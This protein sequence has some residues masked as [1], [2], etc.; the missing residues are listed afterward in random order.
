[1]AD[2]FT[3]IL[4]AEK[5]ENKHIL[6]LLL[7]IA[8]FNFLGCAQSI[9]NINPSDNS[10]G[11]VL[12][13][14]AK[15]TEIM[16]DYNKSDGLSEGTRLDV[17]RMNVEGMDEPVKLGEVIVQ[18]VGDKMS[19]AKLAVITSSLKME[20]GDRVFTHPITVVTDESWISR[21][22]PESGWKSE[23]SLPNERDWA[24]CKIVSDLTNKPAVRQLM[25][26]T[27]A[28]PIWYPNITSKS[29]DIFFRKVFVINADVTD[30]RLD[31]ICGGRANIYLNDTW[32]GEIKEPIK[33]E[34]EDWPKI[35]TFKAKSFLRK[36][37]NVIAVQVFRDQKSVVPPALIMAIKIQTSLHK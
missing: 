32:I 31:I 17:F 11:Y 10:K 14:F 18:K 26:D 2:E 13:V 1:M 7:S 4:K 12:Y 28:K 29:E 37:K 16:I 5:M 3:M 22:N 25:T 21:T 15:R 8:I 30:A 19:K 35:E 34:L 33:E 24:K 36:G 20:R 23:Y 27:E 6:F 9:Q